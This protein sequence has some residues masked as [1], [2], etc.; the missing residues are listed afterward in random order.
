MS[1]LCICVCV[2]RAASL[3]GLVDN[4][5]TNNNKKVYKEKIFANCVLQMHKNSENVWKNTRRSLENV[6][7]THKNVGKMC[8]KTHKIPLKSVQREN[9]CTEK[10]WKCL[11]NLL[12]TPQKYEKILLKCVEKHKNMKKNLTV[13]G[14][15]PIFWA[16]I[17]SQ[18]G[19]IF[20]FFILQKEVRKHKIAPIWHSILTQ[21]WVKLL[22]QFKSAA[23]C[24]S[25]LNQYIH[26][27]TS[28]SARKCIN[29][30][31]LL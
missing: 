30:H 20:A 17:E 9:I 25:W 14:V 12:K 24:N 27:T 7:K 6:L 26:S 28:L 2:G 22:Q 15:L 16:R 19:A 21:K 13:G 11:E 18:N 10:C 29:T 5:S 4:G 1:I 31:N 23:F 8:W 3:S